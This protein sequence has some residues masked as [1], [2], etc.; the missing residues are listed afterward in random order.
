MKNV[1][2]TGYFV[3]AFLLAVLLLGLQIGIDRLEQHYGAHGVV[4]YFDEA[5]MA[6]IFSGLV[7]YLIRRRRVERQRQ[8]DALRAM[9]HHV[10]NALQSI[11]YADYLD[12]AGR[13]Q[14]YIAE[15]V[16]RIERAVW[17]VSHGVDTGERTKQNRLAA[18]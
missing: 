18:N 15:S 14:K 1:S 11:L 8:M 2:K 6:L 3:I 16:N 12:E 7:M 4:L 5:L 9:N 13:K 17:E 10:R